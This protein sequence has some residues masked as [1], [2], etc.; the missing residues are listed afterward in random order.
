MNMDTDLE[1]RLSANRRRRAIAR[2]LREEMEADVRAKK[3]KDIGGA[4]G[5][6]VADEMEIELKNVHLSH[7]GEG[8]QAAERV[9][10]PRLTGSRDSPGSSCAQTTPA[11][12][13]SRRFRRLQPS[14][15]FMCTR[16]TSKQ[17]PAL[18]SETASGSRLPAPHVTA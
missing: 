2:E 11:S 15:P 17:H 4:E 10:A 6:V 3:A 5:L 14:G 18:A 8:E 12:S 7:G 16:G 13:C 9:A 1:E